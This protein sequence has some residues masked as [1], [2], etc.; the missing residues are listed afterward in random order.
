[1]VLEVTTLAQTVNDGPESETLLEAKAKGVYKVRVATIHAQRSPKRSSDYA[2][3]SRLPR[4]DGPWRDSYLR[5]TPIP[6]SFTKR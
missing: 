4:P 1:M 3:R 2:D 5:G 6:G